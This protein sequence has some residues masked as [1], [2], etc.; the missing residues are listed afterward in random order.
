MSNIVA[1]PKA[2]G[3]KKPFVRTPI[4]AGFSSMFYKDRPPRPVFINYS[5]DPD[6]HQRIFKL[7]QTQGAMPLMDIQTN[8]GCET[9][10]DENVVATALSALLLKGTVCESGRFSRIGGVRYPRYRLA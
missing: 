10:S 4:A 3:K 9:G 6:I 2:F 5:R 7:L 1:M 8:L